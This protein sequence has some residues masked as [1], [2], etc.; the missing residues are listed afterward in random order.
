MYGA[1]KSSSG[2]GGTTGATTG[3]TG[4]APTGA[5]TPTT[6]TPAATGAKTPPATPTT[7]ATTGSKTATGSTGAVIIQQSRLRIDSVSALSE[8]TVIDGGTLEYSG[9]SASLSSPLSFTALPG[10]INVS[11]PATTLTIS[12]AVSG[13]GTL[14]KTGP[15]ALLLDYDN[16]FLGGITNL[17][18][19][20]DKEVELDYHLRRSALPGPG[21]VR[22]LLELVSRLHGSLLDRHRPLWE[23]HLIEEPMAAAIGAG[24]P[25]TEPAGISS[26]LA[27][28]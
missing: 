4:G 24:L 21:K 17:V 7:G 22:D 5:T 25:I 13:T 1:T 15:G 6:T 16:T 18:W 12:G 2:S 14:V 26:G 8:D 19:S 20:F 11:N 9:R 27:K 23:A 28:R 3:T 10:S